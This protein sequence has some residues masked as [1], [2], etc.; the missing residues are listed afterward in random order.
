L[1]KDPISR[2]R[3]FEGYRI[4]RADRWDRP[5]GSLGPAQEDWQ[6]VATFRNTPIDGLGTSSLKHLGQAERSEVTLTAT[7]P[8]GLPVYP[9]G[10][11]EWT[12][13][14]GIHNGKVYFYSVVAFAKLGSDK[15]GEEILLEGQPT[16]VESEWLV[17]RWNSLD[18]SDGFSCD[19][20]NVVPNPYRGGASWDL[21]PSDADPTGTKIALRGLPEAVST[22]RIY[23]IAGDLILSEQHNGTAGNGTFFWD[24]ITR[25]GQ[26]ATSGIYAYSVQYP[27]GKCRGRFVVIR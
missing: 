2:E 5:E 12:D 3:L 19:Q 13:N 25:N 21:N 9:V 14:N 15:Y 26:N 16:A 18:S 4:Y 22:V 7:T 1:A 20:V 8:D 6:L 27:E 23:S 11:Y 17:P 24:L 10:R